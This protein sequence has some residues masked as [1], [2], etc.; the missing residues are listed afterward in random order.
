MLLLLS[1]PRK[2]VSV[3]QPSSES[4]E[5]AIEL[6]SRNASETSTYCK[7][8]HPSGDRTHEG[9]GGG[10]A[11]EILINIHDESC[12]YRRGSSADNDKD[13]Q[14]LPVNNGPILSQGGQP[15][16]R[17]KEKHLTFSES[18]EQL[19]SAKTSPIKENGLV[20]TGKAAK[21][22]GGKSV[23]CVNVNK[24]SLKATTPLQVD[25]VVAKKSVK[26]K[27]QETML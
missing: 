10:M 18:T 5:E 16:G 7:N 22:D 1:F 26:G 14:P 6:R 15:N 9:S 27:D 24:S 25:S 19:L 21:G 20:E 8:T 3:G 12:G 23:V 13:A 11:V 17:T 2:D 4:Y